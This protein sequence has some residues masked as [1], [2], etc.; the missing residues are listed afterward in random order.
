VAWRRDDPQKKRKLST[1]Q[2]AI[3]DSART[4]VRAKLS[5]RLT[6]LNLLARAKVDLVNA[7]LEQAVAT[8]TWTAF[9]SSDGDVWQARLLPGRH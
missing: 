9:H 2:I 7:H 6:M 1:T 5:N 4:I 3:N 8:E